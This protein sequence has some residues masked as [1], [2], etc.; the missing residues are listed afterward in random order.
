MAK[1]SNQNTAEADHQLL[2][3]M[4]I[5]RFSDRGP[6]PHNEDAIAIHP[7]PRYMK[8]SRPNEI[9]ILLADGMGGG[10][11]GGG[12]SHQATMFAMESLKETQAGPRQKLQKAFQL[13][14]QAIKNFA[15]LGKIDQAYKTKGGS[16]LVA[17]MIVRDGDDIVAH[18]ASIGDSRGY[19]FRNKV[20][21]QITTDHNY[22]NKLLA[23]GV[24]HEEAAHHE[25]ARLL[26]HR[27]GRDIDMRDVPEFYH[28]VVLEPNDILLLC[29]DGLS[30]FV[31]P[32]EIERA[33]SRKLASNTA[34]A[35]LKS[36]LAA[37]TK[38]N[39]SAV[40][41]RYA[42]PAARYAAAGLWLKGG[43]SILA[44]AMGILLAVRSISAY[45]STP[46]PPTI[47]SAPTVTEISGASTMVVQ[48]TERAILQPTTTYEI[49][50]TNTPTPTPTST[51]T[52]TPT[53]RPPVI[54]PAPAFR[55]P[56]TVRPKPRPT[57]IA[58]PPEPLPEP[59]PEPPPELTPEPLPEFTP[60]PP[61]EL[62]PEPPPELTP[63]PPPELTPEPPPELT[64]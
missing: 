38:D 31:D 11:I 56:A 58:E 45:S 30:S 61:P 62:T 10:E 17:A 15:D 54:I 59:L 8:T 41:V 18:I 22:Q 64:P 13:A 44:L 3:P 7:A 20:L 16:T 1:Q 57:P 35:L 5:A 42:G 43:L 14:N 37:G 27:L 29:T 49:R 21:S 26:T 55:E 4:E 52:P 24:D 23:D 60:E 25:K 40:V 32:A 39:V 63:E 53:P 12:M 51:P 34:A 9:Y 46:A 6:R 47:T 36:A 50:P 28:R 19:L 33:L 48:P 2:P